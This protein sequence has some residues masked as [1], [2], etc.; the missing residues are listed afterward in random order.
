MACPFCPVSFRECKIKELKHWDVYMHPNQIYLA[1]G[2]F[3]LRRHAD[4]RDNLTDDES[5]ELKQAQD[6]YLSLVKRDFKPETIEEAW[7]AP[8]EHVSFQYIPRYKSMRIVNGAEF[9]DPQPGKH[10]H[11][12]PDWVI[13]HAARAFVMKMLV[14]RFRQPFLT[15]G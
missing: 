14:M 9:N 5:Q 3:V 12:A 6:A 10:W 4:S 1:R 13:E 15:V 11:P 7:S 2:L 8:G